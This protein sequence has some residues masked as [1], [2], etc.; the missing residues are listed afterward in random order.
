MKKHE[1]T[2]HFH[3]TNG[4]FFFERRNLLKTFITQIF[5]LEQVSFNNINY[6]FCSD[7]FLHKINLNFLHHNTFTDIITFQL[8][9]P[10]EAIISDIYISTD[11]VKENAQLLRTT[12]KEELHRVI[13]HGAL[14]LCNYTD[15]KNIDKKKM[16]EKEDYYLSR[17]FVSRETI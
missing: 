8:S 10:N 6:V 4:R 17:Y 7:A 16:R 12:F 13:F 15:K 3:F 14:H 1:A 9:K 5:V 2:I 11:R